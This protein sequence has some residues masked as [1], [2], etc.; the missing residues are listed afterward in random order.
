MMN[1]PRIRPPAD[2][3]DQ[4]LGPLKESGFFESKAHALLFAASLGMFLER[5]TPPKTYG[6]GIK[7]DYFDEE[8]RVIDLISIVALGR[9]D[10]IGEGNAKSAQEAFEGYAC[11]GLE[12]IR[13]ACFSGKRPP[14]EGLL[15]LMAGVGKPKGSLPRLI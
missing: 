12:A 4:V 11:A 5:S 9:L 15:D 7:R 1:E 6:E 10:A 13:D 3:E 14:L 8:V 2:L